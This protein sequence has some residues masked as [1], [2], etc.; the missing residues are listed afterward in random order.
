MAGLRW[1]E[2]QK[3]NNFLELGPDGGLSG[4][5][6]HCLT[7]DDEA[8]RHSINS[9][10]LIASAL[11]GKR[12]ETEALMTSLAELWV[13]G[14]PVDWAALFEGAGAHLVGLPTYAFQRDRFW[15]ASTA[16]AG[17]MVVAGQAPAGHPLLG[18]MVALADGGLVFTGGVSLQSFPWLAD[19]AVLETTLLPGTAFLELALHAGWQVG[20]EAINELILE[21]PLVLDADIPRQLQVTV[22]ERDT[23]G[24]RPIGIYSRPEDAASGNSPYFE[25]QW[26]RHAS[27]VLAAESPLLPAPATFGQEWPPAGAKPLD[28]EELYD[29]LADAGLEYG[30]AFQGLHAAWRHGD[31]VFAEVSLQA[32]E[33]A[34]AA[35]YGVHPALLDPALHAMALGWSGGD[36][37]RDRDTGVRLPFAFRE[38]QLNGRGASSLRVSVSSVGDEAFWLTAADEA[39]ALIASIGSL[40]AR[41]V[42]A[43]QLRAAHRGAQRDLRFTV[44][45]PALPL[46]KPVEHGLATRE[47]VTADSERGALFSSEPTQGAASVDGAESAD[48]VEGTEPALDGRSA[49]GGLVVLGGED[50]VL[51]GLLRAGGAGV[52]VHA[53]LEALGVALA[54]GGLAPGVVWVDCIS[55]GSS[56][57]GELPV[58]VRSVV[59]GVLGLLQGWLAEERF[60][61]SRLV[62]VTRGAVAASAGEDVVDVAGAGLWGLVRSAQS[63]CPGRFVL[64][65]VDDREDTP[66]VLASVVALDE[67]QLAVRD[68]VLLG[69]RLTSGISDGALTAPEGAWWLAAGGSGTVEDLSLVGGEVRSLGEGEV[70]VGVRAGGVN[71]RDVLIAL[72]MYPGAASVGGEGAGVVLEVGPGVTDLAVGDRVMGMLTG[73]L[74]PVSVADQ[75]VLAR[76]PEGWSFTQAAGVPVAF[77][78]AY[79]ALQDLAG[80]AAR[81]AVVGARGDGWG[82]DGCGAAGSASW[83]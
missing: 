5:A 3:V 70:R 43:V 51:A 23:H 54:D 65:D 58:V 71:F 83:G 64:V 52:R 6:H 72:G 2:A 66:G 61:G 42:P 55:E 13:R 30:P 63:E 80:L 27:G 68:G 11:R 4:M 35:G 36:S 60:A 67:P 59:G 40:V 32:D 31:E 41:E 49:V 19:H 7:I 48:N 57:E 76:M 39:G 17:D 21:T 53:G 10:P 44:D 28:I 33:Q 81:G 69:A 75:R 16:D 62:V 29:R 20:C 14:V 24:Q 34:Q 73:G 78:T 79:F 1:L 12:P 77:L 8:R 18:A 74:G 37:A 50:C 45:W 25:Q 22:G 47:I 15:L 38:V 56:A 26:T 9:P 82:R 46:E